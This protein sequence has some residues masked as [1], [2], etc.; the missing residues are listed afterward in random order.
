[1]TVDDKVRAWLMRERPGLVEAAS[2]QAVRLKAWGMSGI[3]CSAGE[4]IDALVRAGVR[5]DQVRQTYRL[6]LPAWSVG[7]TRR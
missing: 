4:F 5:V 2:P 1:M 6:A 3:A 7:E